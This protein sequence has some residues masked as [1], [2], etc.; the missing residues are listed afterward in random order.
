MKHRIDINSGK[1]SACNLNVNIRLT[2][3]CPGKPIHPNNAQH[4]ADGI[5]NYSVNS[6]WHRISPTGR[7]PSQPE[8]RN[9]KS[10]FEDSSR[11]L[12]FH[13][14]IQEAKARIEQDKLAEQRRIKA[15]ASDTEDDLIE[16][17]AQA[18][19]EIGVVLKIHR[20][21]SNTCTSEEIAFLMVLHRDQAAWS[22][23]EIN[24]S[25]EAS[26]VVS[27]LLDK[28]LIMHGNVGALLTQKGKEYLDK[29]TAVTFE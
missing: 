18:L 2:T 13:K 29:L 27:R 10:L 6:G 11:M 24:A 1:C 4:I 25:P 15:S 14:R 17:F 23:E 16:R 3:S 5:L 26:E 8:L 9:V 19:S 20:P 21:I 28:R 12:E 22:D 7:N